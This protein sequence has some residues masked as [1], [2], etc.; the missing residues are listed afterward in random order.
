MLNFPMVHVLRG[1]CSATLDGF[2]TFWDQVAN[3]ASQVFLEPPIV[4]DSIEVASA[5]G[6]R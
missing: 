6:P 2:G 5:R 4:Y 1:G 3:V